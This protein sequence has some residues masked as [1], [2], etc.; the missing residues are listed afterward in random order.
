MA[1]IWA[2]SAYSK[3]VFFYPLLE[4][5]PNLL[6]TMDIIW[7][8]WNDLPKKVTPTMKRFAWKKWH[9][10]TIT[11]KKWHPETIYSEKWHPETIPEKSDT[12]KRFARKSDTLKRFSRKS[13][14]LKRLPKKV[15]PDLYSIIK[16]MI[17]LAG[18]M[19]NLVGGIFLCTDRQN[20]VDN[21]LM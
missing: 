19:D 9:P 16:I 13:D 7:H 14:T 1:L 17:W 21:L 6:S 11:R 5:F 3:S 4:W 10:E 2:F 12:L 18:S 15:I 8:L 20:T